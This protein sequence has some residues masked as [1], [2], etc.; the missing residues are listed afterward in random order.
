MKQKIIFRTLLTLYILIFI[1][2]AG[3]VLACTT[4]LIVRIHPE[5]WVKLIYENTIVRILAAI[6]C[7]IILILSFSLMFARTSS[8]RLRTKTLRKTDSGIVEVAIIAIE[9]MAHR[10]VSDTSGVRSSKIIIMSKE[11]GVIVSAKLSIEPNINIPELTSQ[12]QAGLKNE[13]ET[14]TGILVM[15][16][17][18]VVTVEPLS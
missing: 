4:N 14:Y 11:E 18:I 2:I 17:R 8:K 12:L 5:Y 1:F 10:Y 13:I 3:V 16:V 15:E 7:A 6:I 9:Q